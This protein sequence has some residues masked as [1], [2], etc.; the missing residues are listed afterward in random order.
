MV[1]DRGYY[2]GPAP[3]V[4]VSGFP[5]NEGGQLTVQDD[6]LALGGGLLEGATGSIGLADAPTRLRVMPVNVNG[7]VKLRWKRP[8]RRCFFTIEMT[9]EPEAKTGWTQVGPTTFPSS[10]RQVISGL[11][12]G[13]LYWFRVCAHNSAGQGPWSQCVSARPAS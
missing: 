5:V 6:E 3:A 12:P 4:P 13:V 1:A 11:Q 2:T 8:V 9:T 10:A 7:A